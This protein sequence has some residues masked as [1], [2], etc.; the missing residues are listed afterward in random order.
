[1]SIKNWRTYDPSLADLFPGRYARPTMSVGRKLPPRAVWGEGAYVVDENDHRVLDLNNNFTSNIHGHGHPELLKV[2][3]Q[4]LEAG[5]SF[6]VPTV[7]ELGHAEALAQRVECAERV[8]YAVSG[9]EAVMNAIRLARAWTGRSHVIAIRGAYHGTS[10]AVLPAQG[11]RGERGVPEASIRDL[12]LVELNDDEGLSAA[13]EARGDDLAAVILDL[14]PNY[15]GLVGL[16]TS[17]VEIARTETRSRGACLIVDE[18]VNFRHAPGGL[19]SL[20]GL[21][22]DLSV[23]GKLIGGGFSIGAVVGRQEVMSALDPS[24]PDGLVH[25]GTFAANPLAM[26]AGCRAL[27]LLDAEAIDR[28]NALGEALREDLRARLGS[29]TAWQV[30]GFGSLLRLFPEPGASGAAAEI[31]D[32][33]WRCYEAG[34]LMTPSGLMSLSTPMT[35]TDVAF[36]AE[37]VATAVLEV[38]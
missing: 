25:G 37:R 1:M 12:T 10:D 31:R 4:V 2:S 24:A 14:M 18:V 38:D 35:E 22:P 9:T 23:L 5:V 19:E 13:I 28:L 6:G 26:A 33:W 3:R 21:V 15:T 20:Y 7:H 16:E 32:V 27:E 29:R 30:R 17:F 36:A 34:V 8:K 11:P